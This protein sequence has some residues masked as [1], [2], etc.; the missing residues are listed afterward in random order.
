MRTTA[1]LCLHINMFLSM[2]E[3]SRIS[4]FQHAEPIANLKTKAVFYK[5]KLRAFLFHTSATQGYI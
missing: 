2:L 5:A 4:Q 1:Y 3:E